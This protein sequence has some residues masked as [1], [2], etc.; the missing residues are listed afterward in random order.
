MGDRQQQQDHPR[1]PTGSVIRRVGGG[2]SSGGGGRFRFEHDGR[3]VYDFE[4]TLDDVTVYVDPPPDVVRGDQVICEISASRLRLRLARQVHDGTWYLN[5]DTIGTVDVGEST[6]SLEDGDDDD[7][8]EGGGG[9]GGGGRGTTR[10]AATTTRRKK[11]VIVI[12]LVKANRGK[13]WEAVLRGGGP[14]NM[15]GSSVAGGDSDAA[16]ALLDPLAQD[17]VK[18]DLLRERFQEENAGFDFRDAE[19]NGTV[20]DARD[21][22]GGLKYR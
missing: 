7:E 17:Q 21:F 15:G 1:Q 16:P 3:K 20:P 8:E 13:L 19:F 9:G 2:T 14:K 6:W 5:D 22:M 4:Q 12:Y 18:K 10:T 11:K